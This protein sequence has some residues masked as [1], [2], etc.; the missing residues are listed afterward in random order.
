MCR[1]LGCLPNLFFT[2][3]PAEWKF[4]YHRGIQQWRME[5]GCSLSDGQAIMTLHM[6]HVIGAILKEIVLRKGD[7]PETQEFRER[8]N[9]GLEEV[10]DYCFR[11]E[12]QGRGTIHVHVLAWAKFKD[13]DHV[14]PRQY[15]GA[16]NDKTQTK[17]PMLVYLED[18][19]HASIDVQC[20]DGEHNLL[21]YVTGYVSKALLDTAC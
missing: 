7:L 16:S 15:N 1:Q 17:S 14:H 13:D 19:F 12:F 3:A 9:A 8:R 4:N 2:I 21:R 5:T 20:G 11:W 10:Y 6:Y 18:L